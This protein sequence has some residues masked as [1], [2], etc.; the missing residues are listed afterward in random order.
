[1]ASRQHARD[2]GDRTQ[3]P[4]IGDHLRLPFGRLALVHGQYGLDLRRPLPQKGSYIFIC[5]HDARPPIDHDDN[6]TRL[7]QRQRRLL[8]DLREE[9]VRLLVVKKETAGVDDVKHSPAPLRSLIH[10]VARDTDLVDGDG[11]AA[12]RVAEAVH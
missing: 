6:R 7:P 1:M 3:R 4:E 12:A 9:L 5:P 11:A 2:A 8:A 10:S